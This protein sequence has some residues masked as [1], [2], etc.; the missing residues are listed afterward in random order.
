MHTI[1]LSNISVAKAIHNRRALVINH[2]TTIAWAAENRARIDSEKK[3][4]VDNKETKSHQVLQKQISAAS[5]Q[6]SA[7]AKKAE[8]ATKVKMRAD[9]A[10]LDSDLAI[11]ANDYEQKKR[12]RELA[13]DEEKRAESN[14]ARK[15]LLESR[16][17]MDILQLAHNYYE[18]TSLLKGDIPEDL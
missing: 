5:S 7:L 16:Y 14:K 17:N 2:D 13:F 4:T 18:K 10:K 8:K 3:K 9:K 1:L 6:S 12:S 15:I 11:E